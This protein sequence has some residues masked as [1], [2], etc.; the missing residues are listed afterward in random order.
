MLAK[1]LRQ[2]GQ[3]PISFVL[4]ETAFSPSTRSSPPGRFDGGASGFPLP[5]DEVPKSKL[6]FGGVKEGPS[7]ITFGSRH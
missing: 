5:E 1:N 2:A 4:K 7:A 3:N 6:T